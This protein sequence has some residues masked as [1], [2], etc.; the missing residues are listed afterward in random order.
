MNLEVFN[1]Q[2]ELIYQNNGSWL[3]PLFELEEFINEN[4]I[5]TEQLFLKDKIIGAAA[6]V[7]IIKLGI[8]NCHGQLV[9]KLALPRLEKNNVK[10][11]WGKLTNRIDCKTEE[12]IT[13]Q[14]SISEAYNILVNRAS[15]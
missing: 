13:N 15:S 2:Q 7:I 9:S 12:I 3:Y 6:A 11:T 4:N 14:L 5:Q 10:I 8:K 1:E